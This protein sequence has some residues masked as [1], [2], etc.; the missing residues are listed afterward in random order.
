MSIL[1][2]PGKANVLDDSLS[3]LSMG[4][5][6]P[7]E[8]GNRQLEKDVHKLARLGVKLM[9]STEGR[10]VVTNGAELSLA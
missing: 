5:T 6:S 4:N 10:I 9:D 8:E 2:H 7:V 1:Y 3:M